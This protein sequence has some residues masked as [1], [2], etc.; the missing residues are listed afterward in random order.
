VA[1]NEADIRLQAGLK[2]FKRAALRRCP[3]LFQSFL[4]SLVIVADR[5]RQFEELAQQILD[6]AAGDF[7]ATARKGRIVARQTGDFPALRSLDDIQP[8]TYTGN[9]SHPTEKSVDTLKPLVALFTAPGDLVLDPFAG[10]GS[11]LVSAAL[12][13]RRYIGVELERSYCQLARRRLAGVARH[14]ARGP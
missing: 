4:E 13:R 14:L 10:S 12:L 1:G 6:P 7:K 8:W 5:L 2:T 3:F 9:R 11:S